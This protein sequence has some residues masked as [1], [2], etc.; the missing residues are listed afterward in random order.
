MGKAKNLIYVAEEKHM[1]ISKEEPQDFIIFFKSSLNP[2]YM[3]EKLTKNETYIH[4]LLKSPSYSS[5]RIKLG[6]LIN[7]RFGRD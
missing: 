7:V 5:L 1:P 3:R 4:R 2:D 6:S